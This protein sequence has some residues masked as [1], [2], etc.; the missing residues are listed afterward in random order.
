MSYG[1][2]YSLVFLSFFSLV[3]LEIVIFE[4]DFEIELSGSL[5]YIHP[6][7]RTTYISNKYNQKF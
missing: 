3:P 6:F 5:Q 7:R 1:N 2:K 4:N